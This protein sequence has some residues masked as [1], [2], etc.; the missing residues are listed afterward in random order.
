MKTNRINLLVGILVAGLVSS[1]LAR[2]DSL[3]TGFDSDGSHERGIMFDVVASE[4]LKITSYQLG[5]DV[6]GTFDIT[7]FTKTGSYVGFESSDAAW[8]KFPNQPLT[9]I[10]DNTPSNTF[11]LSEPILMTPGEIRG[12]YFHSADYLS[13]INGPPNTGTPA[14]SDANLTI[15]SGVR[16]NGLFGTA[17]PNSIPNV[18]IFY[19]VVAPP[20]VR[21]VG[22]RKRKTNEPR[23]TIGGVA[24]SE[25]GIQK[26]RFRYKRVRGN[27]S[28]K[29]VTKSVNADSSGYFQKSVPTI[30]GGR[31]RVRV[32]AMDTE[33]RKSKSANQVLVW[34]N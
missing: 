27:G 10:V 4:P 34:K 11:V 14:A 20:V 18:T 24:A 21:L 8:T 12:L 25:L 13:F 9:V 16:L 19:D 29:T 5:F 2:A 22:P 3:S 1:P 30:P 17:S 33:G 26:V 32:D 6:P 28:K 23:V 31:S 7:L 15:L